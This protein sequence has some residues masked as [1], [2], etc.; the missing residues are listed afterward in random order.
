MTDSDDILPDGPVQNKR[1]QP[2]LTSDER[3]SIIKELL[4][5]VK[6]G[7]SKF[8]LKR[9]AIKKMAQRVGRDRTTISRLW[10][11]AK[12]SNDKNK[13]AAFNASP[14]K[15]GRCGPKVFYDREAVRQAILDVP[16]HQRRTIRSLSVATGISTTT[17][18]RMK[19]EDDCVI[20]P[21]SNAIKPSLTEENKLTRFLYAVD[22]I[23]KKGHG[24]YSAGYD[25]IHVDEKWFFVSEKMLHMY[26]V[27]GE[28]PP[29]RNCKH[30][31]HIIKV[32][33]LCAI[34]KPRYALNGDCCFDGKIGMWPFVK[35]EAAKRSSVNRPKGTMETKC[36]TVTKEVYRDYMINKVLPA[37]EERWPSKDELAEGIYIQ[38]DG[39][40]THHKPNDPEWYIASHYTEGVI[41]DLH[42]QPANSPDTNLCDLSFFRALQSQQWN[43]GFANDVPG[44][45]AQVL[46]AFEE[47]DPRKIEFGFLTH[48]CCLDEILQIYGGNDYKIPHIGKEKLLREGQLPIQIGVSEAAYESVSIVFPE[49]CGVE[50]P[51]GGLLGDA[52]YSSDDQSDA[53]YVYDRHL[54]LLDSDSNSDTN[55]DSDSDT[56]SDSHSNSDGDRKPA[57][58]TFISEPFTAEE[59]GM[60]SAA[61]AAAAAESESESENDCIRQ[62]SNLLIGFA[63][64]ESD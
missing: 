11:R 24:V 7:S 55:S 6:D 32:M 59:E 53:D 35:Q 54:L 5:E 27:P 8:Q 12:R 14:R 16:T 60:L 31:S 36:V 19:Y 42:T 18:H 30:K 44:L 56:S 26:L 41:V 4:K 46:K 43:H 15:K 40:K 50:M 1:K 48:S 39:A 58:R 64:S 17:L 51:N 28:E 21:H 10:N 20:Y 57:A 33:F 9:G 22:F 3:R 29:E 45:I 52:C 2:E 63:E 34:A 37:I 61:L 25:T 38:Q 62:K 47:F 49:H 13:A 23:D